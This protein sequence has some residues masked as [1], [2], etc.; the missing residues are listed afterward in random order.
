[1]SIELECTGQSGGMWA[2]VLVLVV[3]G[4]AEQA[5]DAYG[6]GASLKERPLHAEWFGPNKTWRM[7]LLFPPLCVLVG[8]PLGLSTGVAFWCGVAWV[9]GEL[10]NSYVKRRLDIAPGTADGWTQWLIDHLDSCSAVA[11]Y[12][13]LFRGWPP[14]QVLPMLPLAVLTHAAHNVVCD[15]V[16]AMHPPLPADIR[17][18]C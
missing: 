5:L 18:H 6:V 16:R 12:L 3:A 4:F 9:L 13:M 2:V 11:L 8:C 14:L 7:T 17:R 10:P 1:M 15:I